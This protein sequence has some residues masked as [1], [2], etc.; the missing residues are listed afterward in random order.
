MT[1]SDAMGKKL[2]TIIRDFSIIN[3]K[4]RVLNASGLQ[5]TAIIGPIYRPWTFFVTRQGK[6]IG[7]I[8]KKWS[9]LKKEY[10]TDADTFGIKFNNKLD[11]TS[12]YLLL[13]A[14]FLIDFLH[15]EKKS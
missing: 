10:F 5:T 9:G 14:V 3:R 13:G 15:F 12:K 2:G 1:V 6:E 8:T 4:Y 11:R 7:K